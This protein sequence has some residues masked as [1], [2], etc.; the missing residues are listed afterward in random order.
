MEMRKLIACIAFMLLFSAMAGFALDVLSP[1]DSNPIQLVMARKAAMQANGANMADLNAK[2]AAGSLKAMAA[3]ARSI[4]A[5]GAFLPLALTDTYSSVYPVEGSKFLFKGGPIAD[6]KL[7][8]QALVD[9][10]A[11]LI[12]LADKE[13]KAGLTAQVPKILATCG[14]CHTPYRGQ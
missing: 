13:D 8:A 7:K 1:G 2:L 9:A 4:A 11:A 3:N 14:A 6:I 12:P 5:T 10:A